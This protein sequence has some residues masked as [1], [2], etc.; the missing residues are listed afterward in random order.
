MVGYWVSMNDKTIEQD[1][2]SIESLILN[3]DDSPIYC[4]ADIIRKQSELATIKRKIRNAINE[5]EVL[6]FLE[7]GPGGTDPL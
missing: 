7:N 4:E 6:D 3:M 1:I 2:E 5:L